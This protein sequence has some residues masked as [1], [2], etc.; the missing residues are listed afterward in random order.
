MA[1][2]FSACRMSVHL[3][4]DYVAPRKDARVFVPA[5]AREASAAGGWARDPSS[6][7]AYTA[8]AH[9]RSPRLPRSQDASRKLVEISAI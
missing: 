6:E 1:G 3:E 8:K 2:Y 7:C 9:G 4:S 5:M